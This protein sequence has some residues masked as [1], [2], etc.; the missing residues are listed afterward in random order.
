MKYMLWL[1]V[2]TLVMACAVPV[3]AAQEVFPATLTFADAVN[4]MLE[5]SIALQIAELNLEIA[6]ID[7]EKA[8]AANLMSSSQQSE[9]QA[10][11]SLERAKNSYRTARQNSYLE[12]FRAYTD[13]LAAERTV[14][15]RELELIVAE[16]DF[17]V[18]QEKVRIGDA[19]KL[20]ELSEMNRVE[21]ARRNKSSAERA[22]S[23]SQRV[24][25]R[26]LGL[27]DSTSLTLS[28]ELPLPKLELSLEEC[29]E[30]GLSNSFSL[31]D[32]QYSLTLQ[33]RQLETAKIEGTPPID[34]KRAELN[35]Q[36]A[37]LNLAQEEANI[38]ESITSSYH[39]LGEALARYESAK[40]DW[41]IAQDTFAIYQR[42]A[43]V[44][45]ITD[46]QL[47]QQKVSLL[48]AQKN[49]QDALVSYLNSYIQFHHTIGLD[50]SIQ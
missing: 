49:L 40:R 45:L 20:D 22:L 36:I 31:W 7:Y 37:K 4:L 32:Q 39:S 33:E 27:A 41:E 26:L 25:N 42:Q 1:T 18:V 47:L 38:K 11:H 30:I 24:L 28:P 35:F 10:K 17:T 23:E 50:G 5:N 16:H 9:M 3:V 48:N 2:F 14:E 46:I 8:M 6:Q 34:L 21:A 44:G 15:V 29:V 13:V 19:G 43:E 12:L